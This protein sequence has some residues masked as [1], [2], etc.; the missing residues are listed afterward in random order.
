MGVFAQ[1]DPA[2][3]NDFEDWLGCRV[4]YAVDFSAR[5]TWSDIANPTYLHRAWRGHPRRLVLGIAMVPVKEEASMAAG[6]DGQYDRYFRELAERMVTDGQ[7][8]AIL[9]VGW[10]FNL[11]GS[12]WFTRDSDVFKAYWR[13]I[14]KVMKSVN[15]ADFTFDWNP[16][17]GPGPVDASLYYPGDDVVDIIGVDAYDVAGVYPYPRRCDDA[18]RSAVQTKAWKT[19]IYGGDRGL[20]FWSE[21]ARQHDKPM[22][23]P[24]WGLWRRPDGTGGGKDIP[25]IE[26]MH[27]FI[28]DP[29]NRVAYQAYFEF[30]GDDG[31]HRLTTTFPEAGTVFR[32][33][34][35]TKPKSSPAPNSSPSS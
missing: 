23:L 17:N 18:C 10:E 13:R 33:L 24:E 12:A 6:A 31:E 11:A 29:D 5:D 26:R 3:V 9:R 20:R 16:N 28:V 15:G 30:D 19:K 35:A 14:V 32:R 7:H 2:A 1:T 27:E 8:D 25:Y 21:F 34:F 4:E 22:S